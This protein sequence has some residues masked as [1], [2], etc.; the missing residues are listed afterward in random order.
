MKKDTI[1]G[2]AVLFIFWIGCALVSCGGT[3]G[4]VRE[5]CKHEYVEVKWDEH[6]EYNPNYDSRYSVRHFE[7]RG[8]KYILFGG[9]N[10]KTIVH[11]PDCPCR[12]GELIYMED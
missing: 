11:D 3:C 4:D 2:F 12:N 7:Y 9:G 8:H 10:G 1:I 6:R 5:E